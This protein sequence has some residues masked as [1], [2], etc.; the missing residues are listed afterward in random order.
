MLNMPGSTPGAALAEAHELALPGCSL[1]VWVWT[2]GPALAIENPVIVEKSEPVAGAAPR[3]V[4]AVTTRAMRA[5]ATRLR[6]QC[7]L[8][9][10]RDRDAAHV[11]AVHDLL[12]GQ[13]LALR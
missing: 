3:S 9:A 4:R 12:G 8:C 2:N 11:G 6:F 1:P 10:R 7:E 5:L 13:S